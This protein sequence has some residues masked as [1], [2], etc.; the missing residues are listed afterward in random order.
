MGVFEASIVY[1]TRS[2]SPVRITGDFDIDDIVKVVFEAEDVRLVKKDG[3]Y[4]RFYQDMKGRKFMVEDKNSLNVKLTSLDIINMVEHMCKNDQDLKK[5]VGP[6][7][8]EFLIFD[9]IRDLK[10][11]DFFKEEADQMEKE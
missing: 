8:L 11:V 6:G 1:P 5:H 4:K 9:A 10:G 7:G 2:K 3:Y